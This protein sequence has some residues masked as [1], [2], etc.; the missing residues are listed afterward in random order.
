MSCF[1]DSLG[2]D[3][4]DYR[5]MMGELMPEI[6]ES[7]YCAE[8][9]LLSGVVL[10]AACRYNNFLLSSSDWRKRHAVLAN[11]DEGRPR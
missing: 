6:K 2:P 10:P 11:G 8:C 4:Q 7:M 9:L 1:I 5:T 3:D